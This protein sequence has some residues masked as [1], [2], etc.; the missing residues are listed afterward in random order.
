MRLR[1]MTPDDAPRSGP[2]HGMMT[3]HVSGDATRHRTL[4]APLGI[5]GRRQAGKD[6][7]QQ[8]V[9]KDHLHRTLQ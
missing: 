3:R 2:Q 6:Q 9:S 8:R 7:S 4:D 1:L 5:C